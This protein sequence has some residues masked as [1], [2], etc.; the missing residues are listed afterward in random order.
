[1]T[2]TVANPSEERTI[3]I[4]GCGHLGR[5][6][7]RGLID[8]GFLQER[9]LVSHGGSPA[10]LEEIRKAGLHR[11]LSTNPEICRRADIIILA[12][13]PQS[14]QT[15][16]ELSIPSGT[17]A[18]SCMAGISTAALKAKLGIDCVRI[19]P[20]GPDTIA[21]GKGIAAVYPKNDE[22]AAL[23]SGMGLK[24]FCLDDEEMMHIFTAGVCLTAALLVAREKGLDAKP[25]VEAVKQD[26]PP[27]EE[28]YAWALDA[29][30]NLSSDEEEEKYINRMCTKGGITEAI[31]QSLHRRSSLLEALHDGIKRSKEISA[32][33]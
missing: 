29:L 16:G 25:A 19:M 7:A 26:F 20:S 27:F 1:M 8:S 2:E 14:F 31:V 33:R 15:L 21:A 10:T 9:L 30:P 4:I 22:V 17:L 3:G 23:L 32:G 6:L 5:S 12:V 24:F 18:V 28:I 11:N 13:R